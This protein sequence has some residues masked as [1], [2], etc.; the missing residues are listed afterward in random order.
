M[1]QHDNVNDNDNDDDNDDNNDHDTDD[2]NENNKPLPILYDNEGALTHIINGTIK[3]WT[4]HID[5]C[6]HNSR[7]VHQHS[8]VKCSWVSTQEN[9]AD[10][11]TKALLREKQKKFTKVMSLC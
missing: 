9:V 8:I 1:K 4:K 6:Y 2:D 11:F 5:V 3:A 7:N 10:I